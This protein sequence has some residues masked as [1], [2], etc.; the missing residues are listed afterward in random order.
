M[1]EPIYRRIKDAL[2]ADIA[3]G[4]LRPGERVP[5][6]HEIVAQY[7]V[8]RMT[9]NRVL[10]QLAHEGL[11]ERRRGSGTFVAAPRPPA[12]FLAVRDVAAEIAERGGRHEALTVECGVAAADPVV[13]G[14][15]GLAAGADLFHTVIVHLEDGE[16]IQLEDRFVNPAYAPGYLDTDFSAVTPNAVLTAIG[17]PTEAEQVVEAILPDARTARLLGIGAGTACLRLTRTTW[18]GD[19]AATFVRVTAPGERFRLSARFV[20]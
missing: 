19:V 20:P 3:G 16:P 17:R 1:T 4:R 7:G 11:V 9:A 18:V 8:S 5:S 15:L 12:P 13:A 6:E 10:T 2:S 14:A